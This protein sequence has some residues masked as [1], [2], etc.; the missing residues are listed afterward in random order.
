LF[1]CH[2]LLPLHLALVSYLFH[3]ELFLPKRVSAKKE[4]SRKRV[5]AKILLRIVLFIFTIN[6]GAKK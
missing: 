5:I 6:F 1:L 2:L 3:P 4:S